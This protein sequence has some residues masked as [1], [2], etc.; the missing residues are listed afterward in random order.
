MK[1]KPSN[2][3][4]RKK[5]KDGY[6]VI[7]LPSDN[8]E[9][10]K[11]LD[12]NRLE[13]N[14]KMVDNISYAIKHKMAAIEVFSFKNSNFVVIMNRRD[15]KENLQNIFNFSMKRDDYETCIKTRKVIDK[16]NKI[17]YVFNCKKIKK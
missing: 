14:S 2:N 4:S 17:S 3:R 6:E 10:E 13:I 15:F 12:A 16:L 5:K 8:T 7:E 1:K 11:Y 9:M